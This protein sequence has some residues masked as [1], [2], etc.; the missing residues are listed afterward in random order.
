LA[1]FLDNTDVLA[2]LSCAANEVAKYDG[3][4]WICAQDTDIDTTYTASNGLTLTGTV[5]TV[6]APTCTAT[7]KLSWNGTSFICSPDIDTDTNLT[8]A[9]VDALQNLATIDTDTTYTNGSG[10]SLAGT[11]FSINAA[12]CTTTDKLQWNG[13]AFVC[14]TDVDTDTDTTYT[15][16]TGLT[17]T[18]T[19]FSIDNGNIAPAWGN[20]TSVPADIADGDDDTTYTAGTGL[21]LTGTTFSLSGTPG[22]VTS[23]ATGNGLSG[24][25]ITGTG[26]IGINAPTCT[27]TE[28]LTW[29][30][31]AFQ[32]TADIDNDTT[33][34]GGVGIAL[35]GTVLSAEDPI[36]GNEVTTFTAGGGLE[37]AG[38]GTA[39]SPYTLG[40]LTSCTDGQVLSWNNTLAT[41]ECSIAAGD[42]DWHVA[43]GTT[44]PTA[45][46]DSIWTNGDVGVGTN[47]PKRAFHLAGANGV[48][49]ISRPADTTSLIFDRYSGA[50]TENTLTSVL[51]GLD[52]SGLGAGNF[53]FANY[54]EAVSGAGYTPWLSFDIATDQASL[55]FYGAGT[56]DDT[57]P[58]RLLGVEAD[59]SIVEVAPVS[60]TLASLACADGQ[61]AVWN[62]TT[63][64]WECGSASGSDDDW[65]AV[66]GTAAP[67][68]ITDDIFTQGDVSIGTTTAQS[69]F[70][71][72]DS[73]NTTTSGG[74]AS[75]AYT[76]NA[77]N[78]V[79][80][81][82]WTFV[83]DNG[84]D[85]LNPSATNRAW[86]HEINDTSSANV[87]PTS[88]QG[89]NPDGYVYPEASAPT[90]VGDTF[91]MTHNTTIDASTDP[92]QV[93]FYWNQRGDSNTT[94]LDVQTNEN[95]AGWVTRGT[96]GTGGPDVA[97]GGAQVWNNE[98]LDLTGLISGT[99]TQIR[100]FLTI[101]GG[102][103]WNNDFGLDTITIS[104]TA[105]GSG[106]GDTVAEIYNADATSDVD[107]LRL[108]S[109]VGGTQD[110][111]FRVDSDGDVYSDGTSFLG[112]GADIAEMYENTDGAEIGDVVVFDS[113]R[114]VV[115]SSEQNAVGLA[116]IVA[117]K[118]AVVLGAGIDGVPVALS[119]R[120]PVKFSTENGEVKRGDYLTSGVDGRAVRAVSAGQVI[121]T[122]M[123]DAVENGFVEVF[124]GVGYWAPSDATSSTEET[125]TISDAVVTIEEGETFAKLIDDMWTVLADVAFSAKV[126]FEDAVAFLGDVTFVDRVTFA[127]E[128][129][130]GYALMQRGQ[131]EARINFDKAFIQEPVITITAKDA[132]VTP[133]VI[134]AS[135]S[136][137]T[138]ALQEEAQ[139][140]IRI[141]W[142]ALAIVVESDDREN[143]SEDIMESDTQEDSERKTE[144]EKENQDQLQNEVGIPVTD[145]EKEEEA[146]VLSNDEEEIDDI[147]AKA[148]TGAIEAKDENIP[149]E[150]ND[151][152]EDAVGQDTAA[153][154]DKIT[155]VQED[156]QSN[157]LATEK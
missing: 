20:I 86:S 101:G 129:M 131:K 16:S 135:I 21:S 105:A 68:A 74:S 28:K 157:E 107:L 79:D 63:S 125:I 115:K 152:Q 111:K 127:D 73:I 76:F 47:D 23:V 53:F 119:G 59:G 80:E 15:A 128:D 34:T 41:W 66:G 116:G 91:H 56:F 93:E 45:I 130:G 55:D 42:N 75:F 109:D 64:L 60:D 87:G 78:D 27:A 33:Y 4:A 65:Y 150:N 11:T 7:E 40:L 112:G 44:A 147:P 43:L 145:E 30:G 67:T 32:C 62:N 114:S 10:L 142:I 113:K 89:G 138:I 13:S 70:Y 37:R 61:V 24:G 97:T 151:L 19:A 51:M 155:E 106:Y 92:W 118:P 2:G 31:T 148:E 35:T 99:S 82:A 6:N 14:G 69:R 52:S 123:E 134:D 38:A 94:I 39:A 22:T 84:A 72:E 46:G 137:F 108:S 121:G 36:I 8:E 71:V 124:V 140:D 88:G 102:T 146:E 132:F 153:E 85:G 95:G 5:F 96:Y 110:V 25:P 144:Q 154:S 149:K 133:I 120:V 29:N 98:I 58:A 100:F 141:N 104:S 48:A 18:G 9:E 3:S 143:L 57:T 103:V 139:Q 17:L 26:T 117:T 126:I 54:N 83:S 81:T 136:G 122:A 90:V 50:D 49:R 156:I 77:D 1:S 12:T